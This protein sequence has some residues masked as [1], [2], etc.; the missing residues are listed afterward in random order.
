[1]VG[2][3]ENNLPYRA[4]RLPLF[5]DLV[6]AMDVDVT[7][8]LEEYYLHGLPKPCWMSQPGHASCSRL[9]LSSQGSANMSLDAT[10]RSR[11]GPLRTAGSDDGAASSVAAPTRGE[12]GCLKGL[13]GKARRGNAALDDKTMCRNIARQGGLAC[14]WVCTKTNTTAFPVSYHPPTNQQLGERLLRQY[15]P[16]R[17]AP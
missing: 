17:R 1:M 3:G 2:Q 4:T 11:P 13:S 16:T 10:T 14:R 7:G 6:Q 9:A 5:L 8:E 15:N 12:R